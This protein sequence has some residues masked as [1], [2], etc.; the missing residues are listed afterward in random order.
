MEISYDWEFGQIYVKLN[1]KNIKDL[2]ENKR[3]M[4]NDC[5]IRIDDEYV[6]PEPKRD[7]DAPTKII[8]IGI[9]NQ[10]FDLF[11]DICKRKKRKASVQESCLERVGN[12]LSVELLRIT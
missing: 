5:F 6:V 3:L 8:W 9:S 12:M 7:T 4:E 2:K 11:I 10:L 1:D